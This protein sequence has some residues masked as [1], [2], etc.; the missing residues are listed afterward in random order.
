MQTILYNLWYF[1]FCPW[2]GNP[3][4]LESIFSVG[5]FKPLTMIQYLKCLILWFCF[6][7]RLK[8][9]KISFKCKQFFIQLRK[10]LVSAVLHLI[11]KQWHFFYCMSAL[12]WLILWWLFVFYAIK[13]PVSP[14]FW[15]FCVSNRPLQCFISFLFHLVCL[16]F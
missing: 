2:K 15:L 16:I 10:E 13:S 8:I 7:F 11:W 12:Y 5:V 9:V 6:S 4:S 3:F 1:I 14:T